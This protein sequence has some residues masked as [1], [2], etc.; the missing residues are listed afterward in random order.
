[1]EV[2]PAV[3]R[4]E[5]VVSGQC[6]MVRPLAEKR[7][8]DLAFEIGPG[9]EEVEQDQAKV[10]QI[11]AN[12]LSNAVKFTPEGGR[13]DVSRPGSSNE[14]GAG[15]RGSSPG[16]GRH[17]RGNR[18]RRPADDLREVS[19]GQRLSGRDDAMTR[20]F[21]GTGSACRS[22]GSSAGCWA[23]MSTLESQLGRGSRFTVHAAACDWR[24]DDADEPAAAPA[25]PGAWPDAAGPPAVRPARREFERML[26]SR[27]ACRGHPVHRRRLQRQ[28]RPGGL[29]LYPPPPRHA[30]RRRSDS[31]AEPDTTNNRMELTAVVR[32]LAQLK[33]PTRGG[34]GHRQRL[35]G[36]RAFRV[37]AQVEGPGLEAEGKGPACAGQE[38]GPLAGA[39][40]PCRRPTR[41]AS[42]MSPATP[43]TRRTRPATGWP[44]RPI[45]G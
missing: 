41:S 22:S 39:R 14:P 1:M 6:D 15:S 40:P 18:R 9:L 25:A 29:G 30:A 3:F 27:T 12:L 31:G 4:L 21:S 20:E 17:G 11:L 43:A 44:S 10:Q 16:G 36:H 2:R 7:Q 35:R 19:P 32:G 13:V 37:D 34:A 42:A 45:S 26:D 38:R 28:S 5:S 33:R 8:I 24:L 23:A